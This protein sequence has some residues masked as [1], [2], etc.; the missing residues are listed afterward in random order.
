MKSH[1]LI[2]FL[3]VSLFFLPVSVSAQPVAKGASQSGK[4]IKILI[5]HSYH[6]EMPWVSEYTQ[7]ILMRFSQSS[8]GQEVQIKHFYLDTKR[9]PEMAQTMAARAFQKY[10]KWRPD[11]VFAC[12]DNAQKYFVVPYLKDKA[13]TPVVFLGV[14]AD[15][16][17]YGYPTP[18][19]TGVLERNHIRLTMALLKRLDPS[20]ERI[21]VIND[22]SPTGRIVT[23]RIKE[24]MKEAG[25]QVIGYYNTNSYREWKGLIKRFQSEVDAIYLITY[26]TLKDERGRHVPI[27]DVVKW[28]VKHSRLPDATNTKDSVKNGLLCSVAIDGFIHGTDAAEM[29]IKI[30]KGTPPA[31]IPI[32]RTTRGIRVINRSRA[33]VLGIRIPTYILEG[34]TFYD[35]PFINSLNGATGEEE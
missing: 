17:E 26:Y 9:R 19:I 33:K 12:D 4:G 10:R 21:A 30:L 23:R 35:S 18:N 20:V 14:N 1:C 8:L 11:L 16:E 24:A 32:T 31:Q 22:D 5:V 15:P 13:G 29:A 25:L 27:L 7:G 34:T 6:K 3:A 2:L 28:L